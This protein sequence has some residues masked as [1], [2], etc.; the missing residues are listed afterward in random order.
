MSYHLS[1]LHMPVLKRAMALTKLFFKTRI[2]RR[3]RHPLTPPGNIL[4][5]AA[6]HAVARRRRVT[7]LRICL[8]S[9]VF[10]SF[11][12][13]E[14]HGEHEDYFP[15]FSFSSRPSCPS[16]LNTIYV[17]L[18]FL[19]IKLKTNGAAMEEGISQISR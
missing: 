19:L 8:C 11:L 1:A 7:R 4:A 10:S 2:I 14:E 12:H 6:C 13:H 15:L 9:P 18:S 5:G 17:Y 16:W 3:V